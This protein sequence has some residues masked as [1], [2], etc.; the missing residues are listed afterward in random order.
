LDGGDEYNLDDFGKKGGG[1]TK[2]IVHCQRL[3]EGC[4]SEKKCLITCARRVKFGYAPARGLIP[5]RA[6]KREKGKREGPSVLMG[7]VASMT[8]TSEEKKELK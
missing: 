6:R 1:K 3:G 8:T 5:R 2:G 4:R 7:S